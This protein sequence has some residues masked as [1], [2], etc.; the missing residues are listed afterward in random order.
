MYDQKMHLK[1]RTSRQSQVSRQQTER[2]VQKLTE[3]PLQIQALIQGHDKAVGI[4]YDYFYL[5]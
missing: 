1:N 5:I 4:I 3:N 2:E